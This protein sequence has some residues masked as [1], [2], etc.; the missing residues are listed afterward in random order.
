MNHVKEINLCKN[1][2]KRIDISISIDDLDLSYNELDSFTEEDAQKLASL[3]ILNISHNN[4]Y[5]NDVNIT[6]IKAIMKNLNT[7]TLFD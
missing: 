1:K 3:K 7:E 5:E 2:I 6:K 4:F